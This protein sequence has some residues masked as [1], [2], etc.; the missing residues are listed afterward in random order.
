V[1]Y[2][3]LVTG[4]YTYFGGLR[5]VMLTDTFQCL[6]FIIGG[7]VGLAVAFVKVSGLQGLEDRLEREDELYFLRMLKS[8]DDQNY[9]VTGMLLGFSLELYTHIVFLI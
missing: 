7:F 6:F 8:V 9:P 3:I 4:A 1:S 2:I 5:A